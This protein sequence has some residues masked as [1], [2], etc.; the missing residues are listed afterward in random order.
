M[1]EAGYLITFKHKGRLVIQFSIPFFKKSKMMNYY[2][3]KY[4]GMNYRKGIEEYFIIY[5]I[6]N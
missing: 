2:I 1:C 3:E 4:G 6:L 5:T